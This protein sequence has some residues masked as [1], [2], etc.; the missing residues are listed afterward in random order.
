[1]VAASTPAVA[2]VGEVELAYETIGD[3]ERPTVLLIMGLG[4]YRHYWPDGFCRM[5]ADSGHHVVRFDNRDVGD[6][7]HLADH[8]PVDIA[9]VLA[10]RAAPPYSLEDLADDTVGLI[11]ALGLRSAHLVGMSLGGM[12]A[13]SVAIGH[14]DRIGSLTSFASTTNDPTVGGAQPEAMRALTAAPPTTREGMAEHAVA[15]ARVIGS[16]GFDLDEGWLRD[17]GRRAF[18]IGVDPAGLSRQT[19]A[20]LTARDRTPALRSLRVPTL[21]VHGAVDPLCD[22]SGGRAT[23]AAV[24]DA[25]LMVVDGLG[26]D[27]PPG[28]WPSLVDV[29]M[30]IV[31]RGERRAAGR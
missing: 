1:M 10:G 31:Q 15:T 19:A 28:F 7:T 25:D 20:A 24:P 23:A 2:R 30:S 3:P 16:T 26:H 13:Q 5:L 9:A 12:I 27:L 14:P 4:G 8:G 6:S 21:V 18:D 11:E 29:V 17:R 22:V